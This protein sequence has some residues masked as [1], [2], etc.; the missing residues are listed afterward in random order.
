[1]FKTMGYI[2]EPDGVDFFVDPKPLTDKDKSAI[3]EL[4]AYYKKT[5]RKRMIA[6][7]PM[8]PL[9]SIRRTKS[10]TLIK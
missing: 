8:R 9:S 4:I 6:T 2:K 7:S 3:S 1:M 5:G 10:L